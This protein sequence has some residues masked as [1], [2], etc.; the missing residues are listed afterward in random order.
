MTNRLAPPLP[1]PRRTA[2]VAFETHGHHGAGSRQPSRLSHLDLTVPVRQTGSRL[3]QIRG[4]TSRLDDDHFF[5]S[6]DG[7]SLN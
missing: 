4:R 2:T 1:F 6:S 5:D 3:S 7:R